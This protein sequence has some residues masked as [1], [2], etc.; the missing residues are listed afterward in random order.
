MKQ[1]KIVALIILLC[2]LLC[3]CDTAR[4]YTEEHSN[5]AEQTNQISEPKTEEYKSQET[6][7]ETTEQQGNSGTGEMPLI[8]IESWKEYQA[9]LKAG[10]V[11]DKFVDYESISMFGDFNCLVFS[12]DHNGNPNY[13]VYTYSL[14]NQIC[15]FSMYI[16]EI[17]NDG[18]TM[19]K[20]TDIDAN[21]MRTLDND[22]RG[23][24]TANGIE[25][26]YLTGK[27][28]SIS[29]VNNGTSYTLLSDDFAISEYELRENDIISALLTSQYDDLAELAIFKDAVTEK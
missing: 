11:S 26:R 10:V 22:A 15:K 28:F 19:D 12:T 5:K 3:A 6:N 2:I 24:Y 20:I 29:W 18:V 27:L 13:N 4:S 9:L 1:K 21:D 8:T 25:Y 14:Q 7:E 16:Y 23:A 17:G